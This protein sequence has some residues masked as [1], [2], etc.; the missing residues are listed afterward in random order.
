MDSDV[1]LQKQLHRCDLISTAHRTQALRGMWA[2]EEGQEG[3]VQKMAK[4]SSDTGSSAAAV[5]ISYFGVYVYGS[6]NR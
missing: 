3:K 5:V 2:L 1:R 4:N 6:E